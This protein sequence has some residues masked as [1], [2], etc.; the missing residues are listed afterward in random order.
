MQVVTNIS[1]H[2]G[3]RTGAQGRFIIR[4]EC[5]SEELSESFQRSCVT[6]LAHWRKEG[7]GGARQPFPMEMPSGGEEA[8]TP[9]S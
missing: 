9:R 8:A 3:K 6:P 5:R 2:F 7:G 4:E 1:F